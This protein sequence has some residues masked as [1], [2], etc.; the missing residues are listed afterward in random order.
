M[1]QKHHRGMLLVDLSLVISRLSDEGLLEKV[2]RELEIPFVRQKEMPGSNVQH[3][4]EDL[5]LQIY[6]VAKGDRDLLKGS[7]RELQL[8]GLIKRLGVKLG[9]NVETWG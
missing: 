1:Q 3:A 9:V 5:I 2:L 6:K 7:W 8:I 4:A